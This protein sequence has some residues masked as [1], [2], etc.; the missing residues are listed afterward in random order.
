RDVERQFPPE[1]DAVHE[2]R[3]YYADCEEACVEANR[4]R[5]AAVKEADLYGAM[6]RLS[7][8]ESGRDEQTRADLRRLADG[9]RTAL[10]EIRELGGE[11]RW[12]DKTNARARKSFETAV[13]VYPTEWIE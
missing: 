3:A 13:Q 9:Y 1:S 10:G 2:A 7:H 11:L 12:H 4:A 6:E 8:V 5:E